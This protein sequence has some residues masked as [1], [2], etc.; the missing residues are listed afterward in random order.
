MSVP[1]FVHAQNAMS[2]KTGYSASVANRLT[3]NGRD[4]ENNGED[5]HRNL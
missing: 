1:Y 2:E 5:G 4:T 3:V